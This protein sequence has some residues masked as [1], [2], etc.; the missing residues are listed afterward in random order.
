[1]NEALL[2]DIRT[3]L[4]KSQHILVVSHIRPDGDAVG[5]TLGLGLA[6]QEAGKQ[7]QMVLS[8][9]VPSSFRYLPGVEKISREPAGEVDLLIAVDCSDLERA[10][11]ALGGYGQPDI[12]IDHHIT[13]LNFAKINLVDKKAVSATEILAENLQAF[14]L[15]LTKP[16]GMALLTGMV[17]DTLGFRTQNLTSKALRIA[18]DL[19]DL[20]IDMPFIYQQTLGQR[21]FE[22]IQFWGTGLSRLKRDGRMIWT[23]LNLKERKAIGYPGRDDADLINVLSSVRDCDIALIFV[24][25][26]D[27]KVKISWRARP[28]SDASQ[29]AQSFGG[30]G[31]TA[32]SG[33]EIKGTLKE[34]QRNVLEATRTVLDGK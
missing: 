29:V 8:D 23:S 19:M 33:A 18:A 17:T 10:G 2:L 4:E 3:A 9:G 1:M 27:Q 31:H 30:G 22:A 20:G 21:S 16:I 15:P 14:G 12:N 25:Q 7:A 11:T 5:S 13:N 6:L 24:E 32:A 26:P 34:V 28:G